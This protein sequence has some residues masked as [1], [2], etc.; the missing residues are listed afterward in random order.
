MDQPRDFRAGR[1]SGEITGSVSLCGRVDDTT[2]EVRKERIPRVEI[3]GMIV[4]EVELSE[5]GVGHC[6]RLV[7][8][9]FV[10][11][12]RVG[13]KYEDPQIPYVPS[14]SR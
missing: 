7:S 10:R 6:L 1:L 13:G 3:V 11:N 8:E 5:T 12:V 14:T 4:V 9:Q 2:G